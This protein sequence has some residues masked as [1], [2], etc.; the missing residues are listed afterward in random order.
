MRIA[1]IGQKGVP[2]LYGGVERHVE[3][4]SKELVNQG[5]EVLAYARK[6]Y[7]AK[8]IKNYS[9]IKIIHTPSIH[10]KHL[11]TIT[12]TFT[13]TLDAI[14][15]KVDVIHYHGVGPSLLS[16]LPRVL[17]PNIKVVA[18]FHCIDRYHQ[19][20]NGLARLALGIGEWT[21]CIFPHE[22]ISVSKTIQNYCFNEF[23]KNTT[24]IPNGSQ[25]K[26]PSSSADLLYPWKLQS[27]KYF[28]MVS[29]LV[30]HKG[31]HYLIDAWQMARQQYPEL[32][33]DHKLVI[34]G[35]SSF[36]DEYVAELKKMADLDKSIIFT[37]WQN[38]QTLQELYANCKMMIHPS[39]N[40]GM[41][42]SVLEAMSHRKAILVSDLPEQLELIVDKRFIFPNAN[43]YKLAEK[44]VEILQH[45]EWLAEAGEKNKQTVDKNFNWPDIALHTSE[46][47]QS[48]KTVRVF[49]THQ[50]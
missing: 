31:A 24:Y 13:A 16:W 10:S 38:G 19:K 8:N 42:L 50:A 39:E 2:A 27:G 6:W 33:K 49:K 9:G 7:T 14:K 25:F 36:T 47:Y 20:W 5:H 21:S 4:L 35:G 22:T 37:D 41:S 15:R 45:P 28:L 17:S 44:I 48:K 12:H 46:L 3:D 40:E 1:M 23:Q 29:R 26:N 30:K 32:F 34:V 18:T 11:D 43:V